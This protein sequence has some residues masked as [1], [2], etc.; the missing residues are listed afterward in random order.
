MT[1]QRG[2]ACLGEASVKTIASLICTSDVHAGA[3]KP[4]ITF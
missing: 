3:T 2:L 1:A 4:L